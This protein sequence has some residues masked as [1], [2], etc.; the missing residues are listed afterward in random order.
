MLLELLKQEVDILCI[1]ET[2]L[3]DSFTGNEFL[4]SGFK[5]PYRL[6][7]TGNSGGLL[8]YVSSHIPSRIITDFIFPVGFQAIAF[9]II[10]KDRKWLIV[11][12]Y[13]PEKRDGSNFLNVL[14]EMYD[15][16]SKKYEHC[17]LVGDMNMEPSEPIM[18]QFLEI[19]NLQNII[20]Q[21]T[22]F[23]SSKGSCIDLILTNKRYY[24]QHTNT[25][26]TGLS[27]WHR[28]VYTMFKS[29][30]CRQPPQKIFYRSY[31]KFSS[32]S[33]L[34]ELVYEL[35]C[36]TFSYDYTVF[37]NIF[38]FV[39]NKHAP[40]KEKLVRGN[41]KTYISKTLR[42][43]M[44]KRARL[45]N[46]ANKSGLPEDVFRYKRQRNFVVALN[47]KEKKSYFANVEI[48]DDQKSFWDAYKPF[49]AN[50][51]MKNKEN[52]IILKENDLIVTSDFKMANIFNNY[53]TNITTM[54]DIN[55][56]GN[57]SVYHIDPVLQA[58]RKYAN[59]PSIIYIKSSYPVKQ[60][61]DFSHVLP[62]DV[63]R[64]IVK[65]KKDKST[66]GT[67]PIKILQLAAKSCSPVLTDC[68]NS[69]IK[70]CSFPE[71]LKWADI[72]PCYKKDD[73]SDKSNF[74]P[75]SILPTV[76]KVF[77]RILFD[78]I[79]SFF[80]DKLSPF[81]CGFRKGFSTQHTL[82]RLLQKWQSCLDKRGIV[83]TVLMDLSKAYDCIQHDLI[84]AKL[85]AYGFSLK[86]LHFVYSYLSRRRQRV[87]V[88]STFSSWLEVLLGVPQGSILGPLFFNIFLNDLFLFILETD[89]CNFADDNT[90]YACD[91]TLE[92]VFSR[93]KKDV[94]EVINW[95][96]IN[97]MV[98]N[99][100]KF[101][102]MFLGAKAENLTMNIC[103]NSIKAANKVKLLGITIDSK[104]DFSMHIKKLCT[105]ANNKTSAL[106]RLRENMSVS[107][108]NSLYKS[109]I[110]CN[111][112]Y[113]PLVWMFCNKRDAT[114]INNV[115]KRALRA[116]HSDFSL[117]LSDLLNLNKEVAIHKR[118]LQILMLETYKSLNQENPR[119]MWDLFCYKKCS[120][121]LR[122]QLLVKLPSTRTVTYGTNSLL[123]RAS[124]I[125]NKLPN[126]FKE[127]CSAN[128]FKKKIKEWKG[129]L[130]TCAQCR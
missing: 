63:F 66:S 61:F 13:N 77:E 4:I 58:I 60:I 23:K 90:V 9:E 109:Y 124:I 14:S 27:D 118:H 53:F 87:K 125:W 126:K 6:D 25:L 56:W 35:S 1:A 40:L 45:K 44:M 36:S 48:K 107:Q 96:K 97:S 120:Y 122:G 116:V 88:G 105:N 42:K 11:S 15:F 123:F 76:S 64:N 5:K 92:K 85:E 83:G 19:H 68:I 52:K 71:E 65:L 34:E 111:F 119:L 114:L 121:N 38:S 110:L 16:Y 102:I 24:F 21:K 29:T 30:Y 95:F 113:C 91:S 50:K 82:V 89:I 94:D 130:C 62:D 72:V 55:L 43:E 112:F 12:L 69:A 31:K 33:F 22:C 47:K 73:A 17:I 10:L 104:L 57:S 59:H 39:L 3:D 41:N 32:E 49:L 115:Q 70:N 99:P 98:A 75:I 20:K 103:G 86:S 108:A 37:E 79:S 54:L 117:S 7:K 26:E 101:Q 46:I 93:L 106:I 81:L 74:R 84:I 2:K 80:Q 129:D 127:L 128:L 78:Q 100:E 51:P 18:D 8:V 28:L 67:I